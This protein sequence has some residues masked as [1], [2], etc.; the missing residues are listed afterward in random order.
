MAASRPRMCR[1][2]SLTRPVTVQRQAV[3]PS[4]LS[5]ICA[6]LLAEVREGRPDAWERLLDRFGD[7]VLAVPRDLGLSPPDCEDV[8][9]STWL[10]LYRSIPSIREPGALA[11]WILTTARRESLA[12]L[13]ARRETA[14]SAGS[15]AAPGPDD[16]LGAPDREA[17]PM[18]QLQ[19][20]ER[21]R[22]VREGLAALDARCREL[23]G[24][25]FFQAG[26]ETYADIAAAL[27]MKPG[28]VGPTRLRCLAA[29][30]EWLEGKLS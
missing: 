22:L 13:R 16:E 18:Q 5:G 1:S 14:A 27:R 23:L 10:A 24:R 21:G 7:M 19:S 11:A 12:A 26:G 6:T 4:G 17:D 8:F 30:A 29:L 3:D 2:H 28:S 15:A 25:L 9:Q 20:L